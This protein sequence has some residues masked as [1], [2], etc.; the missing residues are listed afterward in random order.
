MVF[1]LGAGL[2]AAGQAVSTTAGDA[3]LNIQ[4]AG[5]ESDKEKLIDQLTTARETG[6]ETQRE[7]AA[8]KLQAGGI[9]GQIQVVGAQAKAQLE[10]H[11]AEASADTKEAVNKLKVMSTPDAIRAQH[12][13]AMASAVPN[14]TLQVKDDGTAMT[15]N[16][17]SGKVAPLTDS[18]GQPVKFQNPAVAQAVVQQTNTLKDASNNLD[19]NYK[20]EMDAARVMHKDDTPEDQQKAVDAV[21]SYYR[22]KIESINN[23]LM[24][25]TAALGAKTGVNTPNVIKYDNRGNPI[26]GPTGTPSLMSGTP[27]NTGATSLMGGSTP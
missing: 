12:A 1:N 2:A 25:L 15:F 26:G 16:P 7:G 23:Q 17:E 27:S 3:A 14:L 20:A 4:K 11:I 21:N 5:L 10:T 22:P 9:A 24:S 19:R 13:I 6:L 18:S 8:E